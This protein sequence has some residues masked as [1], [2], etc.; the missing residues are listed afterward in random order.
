MRTG[1]N[2]A[3]IGIGLIAATSNA[4][5]Q[6]GSGELSEGARSRRFTAAIMLSSGENPACAIGQPIAQDKN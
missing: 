5:G 2:I 1:L 4:W 6:I 3:L